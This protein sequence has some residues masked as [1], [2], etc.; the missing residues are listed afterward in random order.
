MEML[1]LAPSQHQTVHFPT[2][3]QFSEY[4][5]SLSF[6]TSVK[7]AIPEPFVKKGDFFSP[8]SI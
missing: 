5:S 7:N 1:Q 8:E 4:L 2:L 6:E 3:C